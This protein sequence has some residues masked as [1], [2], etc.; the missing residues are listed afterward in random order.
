MFSISFL[1][2][3]LSGPVGI[4]VPGFPS[5]ICGRRRLVDDGGEGF[6]EDWLQDDG[7]I[8]VKSIMFLSGYALVLP[9]TMT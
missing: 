8:P 4:A 3:Y 5:R 7:A 1:R 2:I 9:R 6:L